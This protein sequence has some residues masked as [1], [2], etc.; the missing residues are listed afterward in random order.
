MNVWFGKRK[1]SDKKS[2][3]LHGT[4]AIVTGASSGIGETLAISL[5]SK[6]CTVVLAARRKHELERVAISLPTGTYF[7]VPTDVTVE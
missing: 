6:G 1:S 5:V 3:G 4:V 2:F 7:I